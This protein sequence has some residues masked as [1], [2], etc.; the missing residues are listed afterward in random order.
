MRGVVV[1]LFD[2]HLEH[3]PLLPPPCPLVVM[4][5]RELATIQVLEGPPATKNSAPDDLKKTKPIMYIVVNYP[6]PLLRETMEFN[7]AMA[8]KKL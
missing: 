4:V 6:S 5:T 8:G 1:F 7:A 3:V 2:A